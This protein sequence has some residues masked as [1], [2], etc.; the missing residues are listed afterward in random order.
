MPFSRKQKVVCPVTWVMDSFLYILVTIFC[1]FSWICLVA[2]LVFA[3]PVTSAFYIFDLCL[4]TCFFMRNGL[5]TRILLAFQGLFV[6]RTDDI[7]KSSCLVHP[8][9]VRC[10]WI[11]FLYPLT[12][13]AAVFVFQRHWF[14]YECYSFLL[15]GTDVENR[16]TTSMVCAFFLGHEYFCFCFRSSFYVTSNCLL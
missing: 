13:C 12:V 16:V 9:K 15:N 3:G 11:A 4:C 2:H 7:S 8:Q 6:V 14:S 10:G 5:I 1:V